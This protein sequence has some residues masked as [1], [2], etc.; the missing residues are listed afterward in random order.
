MSWRLGFD[1]GGTFTDF[2][3]HDV[4]SGRL[5]VGKRLT[6][7]RDPAEA[8]FAGIETLM[9]EAGATLADVTQAVHGTTLGANLVIERKGARTFLVTTRGFR[10]LLE[11]Q[12]Q[13]R[14]N[15]NDL[16]VDKHPPLI[17]RNQIVEVDER[18]RADGGVHRPLD[19]EE[20]RAALA[21]CRE[22]GVESLAVALLHAYANPAHEEMVAALA[23]AILPGIP[24]TLSSA[25]SPQ[26][27]EY[28]RTN[29]A[30]V[31]A[32]IT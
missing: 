22:A 29:T 4:E 30:V 27:R 3:L 9:T 17:P 26:Y 2:A 12:R 13:L 14:Y 20:T 15:I 1:I 10:D 16:F 31:N 23:L 8:V 25:V 28:E 18:V 6:T 21:Q 7:P 5:V 32:Y 11:I 19:G 24:V